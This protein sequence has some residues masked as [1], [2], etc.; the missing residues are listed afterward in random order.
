MSKAKKVAPPKTFLSKRLQHLEVKKIFSPEEVISMFEEVVER[1]WNEKKFRQ[2]IE[3]QVVSPAKPLGT[4]LFEAIARLSVSVA[5]EAVLLR[6]NKK[7]GEVEV[8]MTKREP[9]ESFPGQW[10]CPGAVFRP[11]E[12]PETVLK[13]LA[14][15]EFKTKMTTDGVCRASIFSDE[16][17]GTFVSQV[18]SVKALGTPTKQG[19]FWP[20]KNLPANTIFVHKNSIIPSDVKGFI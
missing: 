17:R 11:G 14:K 19:R 16:K 12:R 13:R 9:H 4:R 7:T 1:S 15:A 10:H 20:V 8:F 5:F 2:F 6:K 3:H 18:Y